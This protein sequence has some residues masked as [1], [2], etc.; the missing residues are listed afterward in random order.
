MRII[1]IEAKTLTH[2]GSAQNAV[3]YKDG[4]PVANCPV[5]V[6]DKN[7]PKPCVVWRYDIHGG[8]WQVTLL[9]DG[10]D[11]EGTI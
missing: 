2:G 6:L 7:A 10:S 11:P 4:V 9:V 1:F 5:G 3:A 8:G